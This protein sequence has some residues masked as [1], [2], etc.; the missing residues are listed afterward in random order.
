MGYQRAVNSAR[1]L[2]YVREKGVGTFSLHQ[3]QMEGVLSVF[4]RIIEERNAPAIFWGFDVDGVRAADAPGV[5]APSPLGLSAEEFCGLAGL[6]GATHQT[7]VIE[8]TEVNPALD[9]DHQTA[10]LVAFAIHQFLLEE[11]N[12]DFGF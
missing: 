2:E 6:A 11:D 10:R 5:S 1:Y 4:R 9:R 12:S 3:L 7:R 8:F